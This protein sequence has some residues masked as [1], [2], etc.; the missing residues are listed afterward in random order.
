M[1]NRAFTLIELLVVIA[2]I[3]LLAAILFP[4]FGRVRENGR[5]ASCQSNLKQIGM[6]LIQYIG[7]N[8]E[9]LPLD[10]SFITP[11]AIYPGDSGAGAYGYSAPPT[12]YY[13]GEYKWMDAIFPFVK[14][15]K[16]FS[17]PSDP[18]RGHDYVYY[19]DLSGNDSD[20]WG[21]YC[22][23]ARGSYYQ[24]LSYAV[25]HAPVSV[26]NSIENA[27]YILSDSTIE[28]PA[29]TVWVMDAFTEAGYQNY[30][31][32]SSTPSM[33]IQFFRS[34]PRV[35][36]SGT[37]GYSNLF[38]CGPSN[39]FGGCITERHLGAVNV[40]YCDGHVK[41]NPLEN[42]TV[43]KDLRTT[44]NAVEPVTTAFTTEDD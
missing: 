5:R 40:L 36:V 32:S 42:L 8:D 13:D 6:G 12:S 18:R 43:T 24:G 35:A 4:V 16:V 26:H 34:A 38:N 23:N 1:K 31:F 10:Y 27:F 28:A 2:I 15:T 39:P 30:R 41:A 21:S 9:R 7:D 37:S 19:K 17:C 20:H 14:S 3:S 22:I 44:F 33:G 11:N 29:T 25:Q